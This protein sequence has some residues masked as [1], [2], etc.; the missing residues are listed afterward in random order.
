MS[1][2]IAFPEPVGP[3]TMNSPREFLRKAARARSVLESNHELSEANAGEPVVVALLQ[4][5]AAEIVA[6][7]PA[8]HARWQRWEKENPDEAR[9]FVASLLSEDADEVA[10]LRQ[11]A[12]PW[13]SRSARVNGG[14]R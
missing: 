6:R 2:E 11:A 8:I 12:G 13:S 10:N 7:L 14:A 3:E 4:E 1:T 5:H 9:A